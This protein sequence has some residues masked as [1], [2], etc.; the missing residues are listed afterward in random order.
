VTALTLSVWLG[1]RE[2]P[3]DR[4]KRLCSEGV[5][6]QAQ[7]LW[8]EARRGQSEGAFRSANASG[9]WAQ[10]NQHLA[11]EVAG[12]MA[13]SLE[14]CQLPQN[15]ARRGPFQACLE[16]RRKTLDSM[17]QLFATADHGVVENAIN[18]VMLEAHPVSACRPVVGQVKQPRPPTPADDRMRSAL[19]RVRVLRAAARYKPVIDEALTVRNEAET[20]DALEIKAEAQLAVG[21]LYADQL[22]DGAEEFL[23]DAKD[24][25]DSIGNDELRARAWISLLGWAADRDKVPLALLAERE[26]LAV[27]ERL[28]RPPLL[29][30]EWLTA[31]G[32]FRSQ[33]GIADDAQ[34]AFEEAL[35]LRKA[36]LPPDHPLVLRS[37][38][39]WAWSLP[40]SDARRITE[41]E[42]VL[43]ARKKVFGARHAETIST[44]NKLA[45]AHLDARDC[46]VA[47]EL[48]QQAVSAALDRVSENPLDA[49]HA[50]VDL[51]A[52]H[53]CLGH[54]RQARDAVKEGLELLRKGA[55]D[56]EIQHVEDLL[57]RLEK[58][59]LSPG[60]SPGGARGP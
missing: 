46:Q 27:L 35:E 57:L 20:A 25:A 2:S 1:T 17:A 26:G 24:T 52:A 19:A 4:A 51:A 38:H 41:I 14:A 18:T 6:A 47:L 48:F 40:T 36:N 29:H 58:E 56:E 11:S 53:E 37:R 44:L 32:R 10:V 30:A 45:Y 22:E 16:E 28:G 39:A 21:E 33:Q 43:E 13:F 60:Q 31:V 3:E 5:V 8:N 49:G 23:L 9:V 42:A 55:P 34:K 7:A 12:W 59:I 54:P 15:D 50:Y